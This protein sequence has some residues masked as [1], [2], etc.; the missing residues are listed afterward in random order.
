MTRDT[1]TPDDS[2]GGHDGIEMSTREVLDAI[3]RAIQRAKVMRAN[4]LRLGTRPTPPD[5][6][7]PPPEDPHDA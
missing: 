3:D 7:S 1:T 2:D 6:T 5:T 4:D